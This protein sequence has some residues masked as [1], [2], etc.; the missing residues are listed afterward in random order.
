M[1]C[2][3]CGSEKV[4]R[5]RIFNQVDYIS[6]EAFFRPKELKRFSLFGINVRV[7]KN[8]FSACGECG[9]V[10][11][12]INIDELTKVVANSGRKNIKDDFGIKEENNGEGSK[13]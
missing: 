12:E 4:V 5:G 1:K 7:K 9:L 10:W 8:D 6:P 13:E 2:P 3:K 11:S